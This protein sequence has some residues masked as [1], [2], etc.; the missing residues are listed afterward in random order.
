MRVQG[1]GGEGGLGI[2]VARLQATAEEARNQDRPASGWSRKLHPCSF[3][4]ASGIVVLP[5][6]QIPEISSSVP[7]PSGL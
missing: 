5:R 4:V 2:Y 7:G 3:L 1:W 6:F